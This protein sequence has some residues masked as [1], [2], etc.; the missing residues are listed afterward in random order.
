[1][2]IT[3]YIKKY[4]EKGYIPF[5]MPGHKRNIRFSGYL[6]M[7]GADFDMTEI[8]GMDDLHS[9]DGIILEGD[10]SEETRALIDKAWANGIPVVTVLTDVKDSKR[11]SFVGL[12]DYSVGAEY[13]KALAELR[14]RD[15]K[16]PLTALI[17]LDAEE[18]N[19]D[20]M[21]HTAI[22]QESSGRYITLS[23]E[24]VNTSTPFASEEDV[25]NKL[26]A[27]TSMP[28]VIICLNDRTTESVIQYIV[29]K[30]LVGK[31]MILGYSDSETILKAINKG[32]VYATV[33]IE[34]NTLAMQCVNALN[35]YNNNN[36]EYV[37]DYFVA[38]YILINTGNLDS[39]DPEDSDEAG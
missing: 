24:K 29:D 8:Y 7:F 36:A 32:S 34:V 26:D 2:K 19:Y 5:H 1:M 27:L 14:A 30:N 17:L 9:P 18:R 33:A 15:N 35:E 38:D 31:T 23:S 28:D 12:N 39:Y 16:Q 22:I 11:L 4:T 21:I 6:E 10:N 20:D 25:M 3:D 13:G 37:S